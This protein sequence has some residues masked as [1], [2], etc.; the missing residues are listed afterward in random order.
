MHL[1]P[2]FA[3]NAGDGPKR[4]LLS[5]HQHQRLEQQGEAGEL[6]DPIGLDEC[7]FAVRQSNPRYAHLKM[8]FVLEG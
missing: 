2:A 4:H 1:M 8:A 3:D 7:H 5:E 6:A